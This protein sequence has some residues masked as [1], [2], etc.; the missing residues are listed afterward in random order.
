MNAAS[1]AV[2]GAGLAGLACAHRLREAGV[3]ARVFEAQRAPGGRLATRRFAIASFDH[4]AQYLTATDAQFR[5]LLADAANAGAAGRWQPDWP[6]RER[7]GDL[8]VGLPAMN[9]L[10]RH[11]ARDL[12][13]EYGARIMRIERSR[14]GWS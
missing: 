1:V 7:E 4:G 14:R 12:D 8:W 5:G 9:G 11:L 10:P 3:H 13:V 6:D 2:I